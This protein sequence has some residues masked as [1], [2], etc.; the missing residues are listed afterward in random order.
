MPVGHSITTSQDI[1]K[2]QHH[3]GGFGLFEHYLKQLISRVRLWP[4]VAWIAILT[5]M[6]SLQLKV[7]DL[8]A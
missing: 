3:T 6:T 7:F 2:L 1:W 8:D 5:V 4:S